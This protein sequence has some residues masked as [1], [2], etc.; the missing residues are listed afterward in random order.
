MT[1]EDNE[2]REA[3]RKKLGR[4]YLTTAELAPLLGWTTRRTRNYL[5]RAGVLRKHGGRW[6]TSIDALREQFPEVVNAIYV[7]RMLDE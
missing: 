5:Q 1:D 7:E 2:E 4:I 6:V 3:L